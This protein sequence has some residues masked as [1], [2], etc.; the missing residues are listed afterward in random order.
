MPKSEVVKLG[1]NKIQKPAVEEYG[2]QEYV[3]K[4]HSD[5]I[6]TSQI[7]KMLKVEKEITISPKSI[8][9]WLTEF[10]QK[11]SEK[12]GVILSE[13]YEMLVVNYEKEIKGI[14]S[15]V[16]EMKDLAKEQKQLDIYVKLVGKLYQGLELLA[17]LM[18]DIKPS[19]SVDINIIIN[20]INKQTFD[21]NK[22]N[23]N[24]LFGNKV[25]DVEA[26]IINDD[27]QREEELRK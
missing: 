6:P 18:G 23:R 7:S 17:K 25:I 19:G 22:G 8:G 21:N 14:L 4:L 16:K 24:K 5:R 15:E 10:K 1:G 20:E 26:E 9:K 2:V 3:L 12:K 27:K 11:E 13:K